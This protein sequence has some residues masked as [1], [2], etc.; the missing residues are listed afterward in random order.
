LAE[1]GFNQFLLPHF[2]GATHSSC[3]QQVRSYL[4]T[5]HE[6]ETKDENCLLSVQG[7]G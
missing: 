1:D 4:F 7:W 2:S 6:T 3:V 5:L